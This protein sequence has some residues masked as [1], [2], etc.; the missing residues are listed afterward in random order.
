MRK[1]LLPIVLVV[2]ALIG[3][4]LRPQ[5]IGATFTP[6]M[7]KSI[8]QVTVTIPNGTLSATATITAII[9]GNTLLVYQ[10]QDSPEPAYLLCSAAIGSIQ[11]AT[12]IV[13]TRPTACGNGASNWNG[14][15]VEFLGNF[16]KS[17]G[18]GNISI[19]NAA[20]SGAATITSVNTA[21]TIV[22]QTG[23]NL[24]PGSSADVPTEYLSALTL[25]NATTIS[26]SRQSA[27]NTNTVNESVGYCYLEAQ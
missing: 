26:A 14:V 23:M 11:D 2:V 24:N 6:S 3:G 18:C 21:K 22:E 9:P 12:H 25:S 27:S 15:V 8:Q 7:I 4:M 1:L 19:A 10:G 16:V 5:S 13:A 20:T 17:Q